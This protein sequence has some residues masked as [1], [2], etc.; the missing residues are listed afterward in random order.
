M[1][2]SGRVVSTL[3]IFLKQLSLVAQREGVFTSGVSI[4]H[5]RAR[6]TVEMGLMQLENAR[7]LIRGRTEMQKGKSKMS[8]YT[9]K[10]FSFLSQHCSNNE[11]E[12]ILFFAPSSRRT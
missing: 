3:L 6:I 12:I 9:F 1:Q 7:G 8:F 5:L 4:S 10:S 11:E 2:T